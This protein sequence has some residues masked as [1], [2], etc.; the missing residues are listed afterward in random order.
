MWV[1]S[2]ALGVGYAADEIESALKDKKTQLKEGRGEPLFALYQK[3]TV[4]YPEVSNATVK[5]DQPTNCVSRQKWTA[6]SDKRWKRE[7]CQNDGEQKLDRNNAGWRGD[8]A[9]RE[10]L[11]L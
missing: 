1:P 4:K 11:L 5:T 9:N 10:R 7:P 6:A 2:D 3:L 8:A